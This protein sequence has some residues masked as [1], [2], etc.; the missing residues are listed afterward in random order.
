V[1]AVTESRDYPVP[2][3]DLSL[4]LALADAADEVTMARFLA[5]DLVVE[6]KPDAT[7]V[8]D[9]DRAVERAVRELLGQRRPGDAVV[10]E[11]YGASGA[12][13]RRWVVDPVD[14]TKNFVRGVPVWATLIALMEA[15]EVYVGVVSAPALGR[16]WWAS[17]GQGA[18]TS[19]FGGQP[20]RLRVSAV[21]E[22]GDASFSYSSLHGWP[23]A[24][25]AGLLELEAVAWRT[26]AYGDFWQ[27]ALVAEGAVDATAEPE[28]SLWDLAPLAVLVEEA[29]GRFTDLSGRRGP[30][31][32]SGLASN[33][34]LHDELLHLLGTPADLG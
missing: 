17:R 29:G 23:S 7:P 13:P 24:G 33:G 11:E 6:T 14:G 9:A 15:D 16:R 20:R 5:R 18:W 27:Y 28:V 12:G 32:G 34:L 8:T 19:L 21:G 1:P 25:R 26:R 2:D 3:D 30:A 4:A 22:L 10:G 31:G